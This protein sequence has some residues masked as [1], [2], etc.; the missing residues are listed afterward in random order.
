MYLAKGLIRVDY[1][2]FLACPKTLALD[3]FSPRT[4]N[5][6]IKSYIYKKNF[7]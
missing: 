2:F 3:L 5:N 4:G 1:S 7:I 6:I